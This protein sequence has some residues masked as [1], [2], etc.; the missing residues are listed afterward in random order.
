MGTVKLR[1]RQQLLALP[2]ESSYVPNTHEAVGRQWSSSATT[3]VAAASP[4]T[5]F[6]PETPS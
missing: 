6:M 3:Y 2:P 1:E 4:V 5:L